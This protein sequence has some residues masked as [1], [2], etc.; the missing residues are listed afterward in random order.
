MSM[1]L[2]RRGRPGDGRWAAEQARG[3]PITDRRTTRAGPVL[4]AKVTAEKPSWGP[5]E[6]ARPTTARRRPRRAER[7]ERDKLVLGEA[8]HHLLTSGRTSRQY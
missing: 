1:V 4:P 8:D 5:P 2:A 6:R 7:T 3:R